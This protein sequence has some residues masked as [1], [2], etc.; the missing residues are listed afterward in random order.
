MNKIIELK[1]RGR[2]RFQVT[3][4]DQK[5]KDHVERCV[6]SRLGVSFLD[7]AHK[8]RKG[9]IAYARGLYCYFLR[10][11]TGLSVEAIGRSINRDYSSVIFAVNNIKELAHV[12]QNVRD[13]IRVIDEMV[14]GVGIAVG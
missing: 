2:P 3:E 5:L 10:M 8:T 13:D 7:M 12:Y 9:E 11:R 1:K 14:K 4:R 6:C